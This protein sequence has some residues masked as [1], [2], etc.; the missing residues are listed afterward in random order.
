MSLNLW[1][2]S[3]KINCKDPQ[4]EKVGRSESFQPYQIASCEV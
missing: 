4:Y 2:K 3:F 1:G